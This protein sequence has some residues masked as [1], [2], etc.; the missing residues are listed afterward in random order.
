[1]IRILAAGGLG[2][3]QRCF[4]PTRYM[5]MSRVLS[6]AAAGLGFH[7]EGPEPLLDTLSVL[8]GEFPVP[9]IGTPVVSLRW[10]GNRCVGGSFPAIANSEQNQPGITA[11]VVQQEIARHNPEFLLLHGNALA[12]ERGKHPILLLGA[13]GHGKTTLCRMLLERNTSWTTLAED[14]LVV[15]SKRR[16]V[17]SFPRAAS[18]R[19][20]TPGRT[21]AWRG[22]GAIDGGK[23]LAP[24]LRATH[25]SASL[26]SADVYL[27]QSATPAG[28]RGQT[29]GVA[30]IWVSA[31]TPQARSLLQAWRVPNAIEES[32]KVPA[33]KFDG[34]IG[35][36]QLRGI[37]QQLLEFG[38][39][40]LGVDNGEASTRS[41][42]FAAEPR[43]ES[44]PSGDALPMLLQHLV[45][46]GFE[47]DP[48]GRV[49]LRIC[50]AFQSARFHVFTPGGSPNASLELLSL[51]L[52]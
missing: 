31:I 16:L 23:D 4:Y 21:G 46:F 8:Y 39:V 36:D 51:S 40:P 52:R 1:M 10:E 29:E 50:T 33:I 18:I 11:L 37:I 38:C 20:D 34:A 15:D 49:L 12:R 32:G 48:P 27:L 24:P 43:I 19:H 42:A 3:R 30:R 44:I 22:L 9:V 26:E 35:T 7:I 13:S 5:A 28:N 14:V 45:R 17:H 41:G 47:A 2:R 6:F 25:D